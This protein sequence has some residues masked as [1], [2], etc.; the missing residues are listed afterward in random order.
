MGMSHV[1]DFIN[2]MVVRGK[3]FCLRTALK[4]YLINCLKKVPPR[5]TLEL[6]HLCSCY[7]LSL[8]D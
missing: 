2:L 5:R 8:T 3:A 4:L 1:M 6:E 7:R